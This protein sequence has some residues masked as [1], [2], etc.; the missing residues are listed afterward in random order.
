MDVVNGY[1][2]EKVFESQDSHS[3]QKDYL[4]GKELNSDAKTRGNYCL[5]SFAEQGDESID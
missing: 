2:Q 5:Q 1:W 4:Y 3:L